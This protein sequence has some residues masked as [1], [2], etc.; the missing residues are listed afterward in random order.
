MFRGR[1]TSGSSID[2]TTK[3]V[4]GKR[5]LTCGGVPRS[6]S[7]LVEQVLSAHS[8]V[9]AVG[10]HAGMLEV[11]RELPATTGG[12]QRFPECLE[13]L[14]AGLSEELARWYLD[15]LPPAALGAGRVTDKMLGNFLRLGVIAV[16]LPHAR[17]VHCVRDPVDTCFSCFTQDFAHGLRFTTD[18]EH[19]VSFYRDYR[20]LMD[21][22]R[23]VL[24]LPIFEARYESLVGDPDNSIHRLL[25]FCGLSREE[26]CLQ[27]HRAR[28]PVATASAWQARQPIY[29]SSVGRWKRYEPFIGSLLEGLAAYRDER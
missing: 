25:E 19:L 9:V 16:L 28:R 23:R 22:W 3:G 10:E 26:Q 18:M 24:P 20:R 5:H 15:S 2:K 6:G 21:H 14:D 29:L 17:V 7:T 11:V 27:P 12:G 4:A 13:K 8:E 1:S